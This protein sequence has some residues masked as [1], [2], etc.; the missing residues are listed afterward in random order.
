MYIIIIF[1]LLCLD[2]GHRLYAKV[3]RIFSYTQG[4]IYN[5]IQFNRFVIIFIK[6]L[7]KKFWKTSVKISGILVANYYKEFLGIVLWFN[8]RLPEQLVTAN[9]ASNLRNSHNFRDK[10]KDMLCIIF[11][12]GSGLHFP[13]T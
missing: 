13:Y 11:P 6:L 9:V 7:L 4:I 3:P 1:R 10:Y 8:S 12:V 2:S 5:N